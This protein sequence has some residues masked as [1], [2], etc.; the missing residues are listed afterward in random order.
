MFDTRTSPAVA[1]A[2]I[3]AAMWT[4]IP[5]MSS[6]RRTHS[7][8][9]SPL[10]MSTPICG[11]RSASAVAHR[12][13]RVGPSKV[14]STPSPVSL[15]NRPWN[16]AISARVISSWRCK[17][18]APALIAEL[19]GASGGIDDVGEQHGG[20]HSVR[21]VLVSLS[22][23]EL[24]HLTGDRLVVTDLRNVVDTL[25]FDESRPWNCGGEFAPH[26]DRNCIVFAV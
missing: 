14:A 16:E 26:F 6:P 5:P 19:G 12:T 17:Q 21:R 4:A 15:T 24:L 25:E 23:Q 10:R 9:C 18:L 13:A 1:L 2:A 8:V 3:R 20:Q 7:P 11:M 22:G